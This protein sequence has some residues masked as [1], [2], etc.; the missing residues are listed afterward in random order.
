MAG[1]ARHIDTDELVTKLH[2]MPHGTRGK[3][4]K[5]ALSHQTPYST[6][7]NAASEVSSI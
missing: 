5:S 1:L 2:D 3:H 4:T 6:Q 7:Y